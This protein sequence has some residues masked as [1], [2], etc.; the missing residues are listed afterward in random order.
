MDTGGQQEAAQQWRRGDPYPPISDYA[1]I[2]DGHSSA[3]ISSSGSIDWCCMP[4][5]DSGSC[6]GRLLGWEVGGYCRIAPAGPFEASRCYLEDTLVLETVFSTDSGRARLL[7]LFP[8]RRGG[9]HEPYR[10]LLRILEGIEGEVSFR[11]EIVPRFDYGSI[12]PWIRQ[13]QNGHCLAIGG[14]S[15]L[16][17]SGDL[18][19]NAGRRHDLAAHCTLCG[20]ERKHLSLHFQRPHLLDRRGVAAP[21][22]EELDRRLDETVSWWRSWSSRSSLPETFGRQVR[23][24]AIVLKGL[25]N[26]PTGAIAAAATTSLPEVDGGS[27]N[28]DYRFTWIR[29]SVFTVRTLAALGHDREADGF[30]RFVE[31]TAA[32]S[33][34]EIQILFGVGGERRLREYEIGELEGYRG[35][36]PVRV[37]NAAESQVQLDVYGELLDLAWIWHRRGRSPDDDYWEFLVEIVNAAERKW[38]DPDQGIW[39]MRGKPRH[40]VHSK[41]MCWVAFDRGLK[42]AAQ[43]GRAAPLEKWR[44]ARQQ[45]RRLIE[46]RGYDRQRG[47]FTQAF[48]FSQM[49]SALLLLPVFGF[50]DFRDERMMRTTDAVREE[51]EENGLLRR[52]PAASDEMA[53]EEG[54]FLACSFWLVQCLARQGRRE[55]AG[56]VFQRCL[57]MGNDL[58]LFSEECDPKTGAMLGNFPQALTHLSLIGAALALSGSPENT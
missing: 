15:G 43:T 1:Y 2:S 21:G 49:D 39:E 4:R 8:M 16:L 26:A 12:K 5:I 37:G 14:D 52:Y 31:R 11:V 48:G 46:E 42:L 51:L 57:E 9:A 23:R 44:Q 17:F 50:V 24:S 3:L 20:G 34:Q 6:F 10:Q 38:R 47:V 30:R 19:L 18:A 25:I 22:I 41:A 45:V 33:A 29:D 7:D 32:G 27:R 13:T 53:G 58:E 36:G 35:S 56:R 55:A 40:F 54:A 28:W